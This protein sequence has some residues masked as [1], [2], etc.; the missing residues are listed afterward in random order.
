MN[1][2]INQECPVSE[3]HELRPHSL[4]YQNILHCLGYRDT[5]PLADVLRQ[6]KQLPGK[7]VVASPIH[8]QATHNDSTVLAYSNSLFKDE[9][10][11]KKWFEHFRHFAQEHEVCYLDK[12][13]WLLRCDD[14]PSL[15]AKPVNQI[16]HKSFLP[17]FQEIKVAFWQCFI[18][19]S[20]MYF[21]N[22]Q[23]NESREQKINGLWFW[24]GGEFIKSTQPIVF[25]P[26]LRELAEVLSYNPQA[27]S[28]GL[29]KANQTLFI[30]DK[31]CP[32]DISNL[33]KQL[34]QY[35]THW[36]WNN[37]DYQ[38]KSSNWWR[39]FK[40]RMGW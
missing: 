3:P 28:E 18:T 34:A 32:G 27:Y 13:L 22:L 23:E 12:D 20:Q 38:K 19:E 6:Y 39:R 21:S 40:E 10:E 15:S 26:Q 25:P 2:I 35:T 4:F 30:L 29:P 33:E 24:G 9:K 7:W 17:E 37:L 11:S 14:L 8:W 16:L 31:A 5:Y 1:I 36:Y